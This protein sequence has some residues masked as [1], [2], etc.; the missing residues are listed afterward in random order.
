MAGPHAAGASGIQELYRRLRAG[1]DEERRKVLVLLFAVVALIAL[2]GVA[3]SSLGGLREQA[4]DAVAL[5]LVPRLSGGAADI[6]ALALIGIATVVGAFAFTYL[7]ERIQRAAEAEQELQRFRLPRAVF[8]LAAAPLVMIVVIAV[9]LSL[10]AG[11]QQEVS[12]AERVNL[13]LAEV[14]DREARGELLSIEELERHRVRAEWRPRIVI[15]A[16][17]VLF[18]AMVVFGSRLLREAPADAGE[19]SVITEALRRDL[20]KAVVLAIDDIAEEADHGR[21]VELCYARVEAVLDAHGIARPLHE[22][23]L[24]YMHGVLDAGHGLPGQELLDLTV[25]YEVAKFS[26]HR[27]GEQDKRRAIAILQRIHRTLA[28][29][30]SNDE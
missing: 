13:A 16:V 23:P 18:V 25:M 20:A 5:P 1:S 12:Y 29:E 7:R 6:T 27:V 4:G 9:V 17:A 21:A 11:D 26:T 28:A 8:L 10:V 22:T 30:L 2:V 14:E 3:I 15:A 24:E 19:E